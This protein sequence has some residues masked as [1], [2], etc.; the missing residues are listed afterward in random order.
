MAGVILLDKEGKTPR[1]SF[2]VR[3]DG[4]PGLLLADQDGNAR[5]LLRVAADGS[6][7]LTAVDKDGKERVGIVL[8]KDG[9]VPNLFFNDSDES[10]RVLLGES[11]TGGFGLTL[12]DK[13][14]P[15]ASVG[16]ASDGTSAMR[17]RDGG[18]KII[19]KAP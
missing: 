8:D 18:G 2:I 14:Q 11:R 3:P 12:R 19:W 13:R 16:M 6:S 7:L 9:N 5:L 15:R 10:H 17:L 4:S 1:A